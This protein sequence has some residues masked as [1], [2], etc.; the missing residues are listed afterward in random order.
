MA[1]VQAAV[2]PSIAGGDGSGTEC[3]ATLGVAVVDAPP[4]QVMQAA[5]ATRSSPSSP[6]ASSTRSRSS[7]HR[8]PP[9]GTRC[10]HRAAAR[11]DGD[12][13]RRRRSCPPPRP[14]PA[15][16][17]TC[18]APRRSAAPHART[19]RAPPRRRTPL[20]AASARRDPGRPG[21]A[22]AKVGDLVPRGR[23]I[24]HRGARHRIGSQ[25]PDFADRTI[26]VAVV[27][28]GQAVQDGH[29]HGTHCIGTAA[30]PKCP[31]SRP[32]YGVAYEAEIFA[33]KV[34]YN[35]GLGHR[36]PDPRRHRVGDRQQVR[37][38][39]DVAGRAGRAGQP[40]STVY[41][42]RRAARAAGRAR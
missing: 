22:G 10:C 32:R 8:T 9:T 27:R 40:F 38:R 26:T 2:G 19:S 20:A 13:P 1:A 11:R 34:L 29:G 21:A 41:E 4:E 30:G 33:G 6:S 25:A 12:A 28:P 31:A 36:R 14:Q 15:A 7:T 35:T 16:P 42:T 23:E 18:A 3:S 5:A 17:T 37:G 39:L 24:K